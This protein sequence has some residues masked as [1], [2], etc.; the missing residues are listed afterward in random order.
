MDWSLAFVRRPSSKRIAARTDAP[1]WTRAARLEGCGW[2]K[3]VIVNSLCHGIRTGNRLRKRMAGFPLWQPI[4]AVLKSLWSEYLAC[5]LLLLQ[6]PVG[7]FDFHNARDF[8]FDPRT[9]HL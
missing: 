2:G 9:E 3:W 5:C 1:S 7:R 4:P 6:C 8:F